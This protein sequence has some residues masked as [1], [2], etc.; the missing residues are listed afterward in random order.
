MDD[1]ERHDS[2]KVSMN[3]MTTRWL[4]WTP[5]PTLNEKADTTCTFRFNDIFNGQTTAIGRSRSKPSV[6]TSKAAIAFHFKAFR[7][8]QQMRNHSSRG[9]RNND[10]PD[11]HTCELHRPIC[12]CSCHN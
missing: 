10:L 9:Q 3:V 2:A 12:S 11:S 4:K 1:C 7:R 5:H 6:T 8:R